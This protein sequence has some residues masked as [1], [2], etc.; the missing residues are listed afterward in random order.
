MGQNTGKKKKRWPSYE[1]VTRKKGTPVSEVHPKSWTNNPAFGGALFMTKYSKEFRFKL[2]QEVEDGLPIKT[3][4]RKY[5]VGE[6]TL[7]N[8]WL[9]YSAGGIEQ[10]FSIRRIYTKEFKIQAIEYRWAHR[11]SYLQAAADLGIP[12][13]G[14]LYTWEKR[15]IEFGSEGLHD[16]RLGRLPTMPKKK[17]VPKKKR[18]REEELEAE[19]AQLRME[20]AYLKK[21][22]ALVSEREKSERKTK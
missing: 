14:T 17:V 7:R 9:H 6:N 4:A 11:V 1:K 19:N 16:T 8:W 2:V 21:L 18:T 20:N 3:T 5:G 10:L 22:N 15:Y 13:E 12:D